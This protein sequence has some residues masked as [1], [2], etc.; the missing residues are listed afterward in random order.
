[1]NTMNIMAAT[2]ILLIVATGFALFLGMRAAAGP[3]T[4]YRDPMAISPVFMEENNV[5]PDMM[6]DFATLEIDG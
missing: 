1:M 6:D 3:D 2:L 4:E 5:S